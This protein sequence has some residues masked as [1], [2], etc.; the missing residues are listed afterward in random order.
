[1][2][3]LRLLWF[4]LRLA[5]LPL[6]FPLW[7]FARRIPNGSYVHVEIHGHVVE[8]AQLPIAW[9]RA[10]PFSIQALRTLRDRV[11]RDPRV[12]GVLF[13]IK[14]V[15]AGMATATALRDVLVSL[16]EAGKD[17]VVHLPLGAG[18]KEYYVASAASR[19]YMGPQ[20][21]LAPLGF[22]VSSRYFGKALA[23]L[24]VEPKIL[25]RGEYKSAGEN[26]V[27]DS[28]S[29]AQKRQLGELMDQ[30]YETT[31]HAIAAGR[32]V[33]RDQAKAAIDNAPF[34]PQAAVQAGLL[35]GAAYEDE[36]PGLLGSRDTPIVG[37]K[38]YM[39]AG[40]P[41]LALP[42]RRA[43][44]AVVQV[45]GPIVSGN[46]PMGM[47]GDDT[48]ISAIRAARMAPQV[49]AV[50][51]HVDSPGGSALA[52]DRI[53]HE[54]VQLA[55]EKPV[56][57]CMGDVAASGGYY[58]SA[59]AAHV[60]AQPTT[61]TGSIGV[62]SARIA[63]QPLL[64]K[65]G[66]TTETMKRGAHAGLLDPFHPLD[67][68]E[69][70]ALDKEIGAIYDAFVDVVVQGRGRT[71]EEILQ[72][73]EG[74]VWSGAEAHARG[75]VDELGGFETALRYASA[76]A[77]R[78][79]EPAVIRTLRTKLPPLPPP[80]GAFTFEMPW[81]ALLRERALVLSD[82]IAFARFF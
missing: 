46:A 61:I 30:M 78:D 74:R 53:H 5:F 13:T 47:A 4:F 36:L 31:L 23:N 75:L 17:V 12:K 37:A 34:R 3:L 66:I 52:S 41:L 8:I 29:D 11:I 26:L 1:M 72:V 76:R 59:P 35:D 33:T 54:I 19:I 16:K 40:R 32:G 55:A 24:G 9:F 62:V 49:R 67:E 2:F 63:L 38:R 81:L 39:R 50:I 51:L 77:G 58:V 18:T 65:W 42:K 20:A 71:R 22:A 70:R 43:I 79:L 6:R 28:M 57:A 60:I 44:A 45:H 15:Q 25:S 7:L 64:E 27:R 80:R 14:D 73:A 21:T 48:I 10:R 82:W 56:V 68:E 69:T